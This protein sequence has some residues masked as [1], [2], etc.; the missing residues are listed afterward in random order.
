MT[1]VWLKLS[2]EMDGLAESEVMFG[3]CRLAAS[4]EISCRSLWAALRSRMRSFTALSCVIPLDE[5]DTVTTNQVLNSLC[6]TNQPRADN[7][8]D[9][10]FTANERCSILDTLM[11]SLIQI[12][13]EV[14]EKDAVIGRPQTTCLKSLC[15]SQ[16]VDGIRLFGLRRVCHERKP[17]QVNLLEH[18]TTRS[19]DV[20]SDLVCSTFLDNS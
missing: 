19:R 4:T 18:S 3:K 17:V 14:W 15:C 10:A 12:R 13:H 7:F 20:L 1:H 6:R 9:V 5:I 2:L 16:P 8:L 11:S